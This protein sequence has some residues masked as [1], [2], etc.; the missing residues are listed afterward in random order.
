MSAPAQF[1]LTPLQLSPS[2]AS[3]MRAML[4]TFGAGLRMAVPGIIQSFNATNQTVTV[5]VALTDSARIEGNL[6]PIS[7]QTLQDVPIC[8]PQNS[9]FAITFPV[10]PNDECLLVFCDQD[11]DSWFQSGGA[12]NAPISSRRHNI[13]DAIAILGI[14]SQPNK[15]TDYATD[16]LEIRSSD[17]S[18]KVRMN[19][20]TITVQGETQVTVTAPTVSITGSTRVTIDGNEN[21]TIDGKI[22]L[23][24]TH[25]GVQ[26]GPGISGPV[27]P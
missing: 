22:F 20:S 11:I 15:I 2:V 4:D 14:T 18:T 19:A 6:T 9:D 8:I 21:T 3:V 5:T 25:T 17:G 23:L 16:A 27:T 26:T 10:Q 13:S 12:N 24:H 1:G 7:I